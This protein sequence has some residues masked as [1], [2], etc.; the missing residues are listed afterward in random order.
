[1]FSGKCVRYSRISPP[2][3]RTMYISVT[4]QRAREL[5]R[6]RGSIRRSEDE[7]INNKQG[8]SDEI[9]YFFIEF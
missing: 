7:T 4:G 6:S 8:Q 1:M 9:S 2:L 5:E 3:L